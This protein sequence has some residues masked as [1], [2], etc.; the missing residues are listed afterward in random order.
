MKTF[1][2][3]HL[4]ILGDRLKAVIDSPVV[5]SLDKLAVDHVKKIL[6]VSFFLSPDGFI[7]TNVWFLFCNKYS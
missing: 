7:K 2:V 6:L 4:K 1:I 3:P 5:N